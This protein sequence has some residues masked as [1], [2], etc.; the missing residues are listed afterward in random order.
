MRVDF[1]I[2]ELFVGGAERCLT[3]LAL[4]LAAKGDEVRVFSL[5]SLPT[6]EQT[7][8]LDR[9]TDAGISVA[10][11]G[12]DRPTQFF[13]AYRQLKRWL[14]ESPPDV[15]QTFLFHANVLGTLAAKGVG[16]KSRVGGIRVAEARRFRYRVE[17]YA[18]K[19]MTSVVCV[20]RAVQ[21]FVAQH[22]SCEPP[23]SLVIPNSVD[24]ARFSAAQLFDWSDLNWPA[25]A[26]VSLFV[27][28]LHPQKGIELLQSK[29]DQLAPRDSGRKLLL[30]GDGPL[31]GQLESWAAEIG[32]DRVQILPWQKDVSPLM[33]ST[34]LLILPSRYEGMPNVI[35]EAMAA[36]RP[37]VCS[38]VEGSHELLRHDWDRQSF[39]IGDAGAMMD[40]AEPFLKEDS[41][42][43][44]AGKENLQH[45]EANFSITAMVDAYRNHY[46]QLVSF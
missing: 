31:R 2:T 16:V 5:G 12:A 26:C 4:G 28:R 33:K 24:V 35:M 38:Q 22:L 1:V 27:G 42:A 9:L 37:V 14:S 25:D 6:G 23:K 20:S 29:I 39:P 32:A 17:R 18:A 34:R 19:R 44:D 10:S 30:V 15:C 11:G 43:G 45:I 40:R 13:K 3:E 7:L 41:L 21:S 8:L 36:G 46:R